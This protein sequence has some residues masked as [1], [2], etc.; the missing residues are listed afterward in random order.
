[1]NRI[2]NNY[3]YDIFSYFKDIHKYYFNHSF[4]KKL[5]NE[6]LINFRYYSFFEYSNKLGYYKIDSKP[7]GSNKGLILRYDYLYDLI[8]Y[9]YDNNVPLIIH[10]SPSGFLLN[11]NIIDNLSKFQHICF[12]NSRYEGIDSRFIESFCVVEISIGDY[13]LYDGDTATLV[14]LN[15]IIRNNFVNKNAKICDSFDNNLL[16]YNQYT[17]PSTY[18]NISV[19]GILLSGN[20]SKIARWQI[21]NS[22]LKTKCVRPDIYIKYK[23]KKDT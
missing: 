7:F 11:K 21:N 17:R 2:Q 5:I 18:N 20:H 22:L 12:I 4:F 1:M 16:E 14:I 23:E 3:V 13:I 9:V 6:Q 10:P 15:T 8:N 19:P